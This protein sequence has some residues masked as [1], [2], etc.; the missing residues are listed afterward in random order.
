MTSGFPRAVRV[1]R[2]MVS[3][4]R[5]D[6][7]GREPESCLKAGEMA[8]W[9][10][11][12]G[13]GLDPQNSHLMNSCVRRSSQLQFQRRDRRLPRSLKASCLGVLAGFMSAKRREPRLRKCLQKIWVLGYLLS[14]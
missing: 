5:A 11:F 1:L 10:E 14:D 6:K 3:F 7:G 12:E 2:N 9:V 13:V 8:Q 4:G